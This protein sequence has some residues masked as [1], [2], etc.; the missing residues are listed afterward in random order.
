MAAY[1][2]KYVTKTT[3][4]FSLPTRVLSARHAAQAGSSSHAVRPVEI[5]E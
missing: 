1:T 4:D 3:D 2:A 5:A